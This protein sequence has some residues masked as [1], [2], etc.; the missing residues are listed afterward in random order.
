MAQIIV[1]DLNEGTVEALKQLAKRH[2]R[3]LEAEV[4]Q[5]LEDIATRES[6][7]EAFWRFA[8]ES[9]RRNGPQTT[10]SVDLIRED[11]ER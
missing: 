7:R 9:R 1:R 2:N 10:D 3:S 6:R 8:D 5:V 4:R 11:R